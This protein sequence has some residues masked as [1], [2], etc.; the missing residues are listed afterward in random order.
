MDSLTK[1]VKQKWL[2]KGGE[3][4]ERKGEKNEYEELW[5]ETDKG[6]LRLLFHG[7]LKKERCHTL[8]IC[9]LIHSLREKKK[10]KGTRQL[11]LIG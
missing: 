9:L 10:E 4:K 1:R 5:R 11:A 7:R 2:K 8:L 6:K 3:T